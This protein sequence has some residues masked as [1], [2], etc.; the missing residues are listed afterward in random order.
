MNQKTKKIVKDLF[1]KLGCDVLYMNDKK[2][3]EFFT[4]KDLGLNSV[5]GKLARIKTLLKADFIDIKVSKTDNVDE[6]VEA[7]GGGMS[8]ITDDGSKIIFP[9]IKD[10]IKEPVEGDEAIIDGELAGGLFGHK[11]AT[12]EFKAGKLT[13]I[14]YKEGTQTLFPNS[15]EDK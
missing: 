15:S 5:A 2:D 4:K 14:I 12:L 9:A 6:T 8:I 13:E 11:G 10:E 3:P 7:S 1:E